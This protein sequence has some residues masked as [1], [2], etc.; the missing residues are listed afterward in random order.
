[1]INLASY[2]NY[3]KQILFLIHKIKQPFLNAKITF[4][5]LNEK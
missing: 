3:W 5:S 2:M 4:V 1:M